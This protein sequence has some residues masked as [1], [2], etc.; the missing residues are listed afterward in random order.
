MMSLLHA[1]LVSHGVTFPT[2]EPLF[3]YALSERHRAMLRAELVRHFAR[4]VRL[5][6]PPAP[7]FCLWSAHWLRALGGARSWAALTDDLGWRGSLD[8]LHFGV[9]YGVAWWQRPMRETRGG[10]AYL[11]TLRA[12]GGVAPDT[13]PEDRTAPQSRSYFHRSQRASMRSSRWLS[14]RTRSTSSRAQPGSA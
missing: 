6:G 4:S 14:L 12:E 8:A 10:V 9:A 1:I 13:P 2:G 3:R 7:M 5:V 11:D